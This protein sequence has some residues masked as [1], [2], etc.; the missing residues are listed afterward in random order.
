MVRT[1][2]T[3]A[4]QYEPYL[5]RFMSWKD[6]EAY[7]KDTVFTEAQLL[8]IRPRDIVRYMCKMA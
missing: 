3:T 1:K 6:G 5:R 2:K 4:Q 7:E 8:E